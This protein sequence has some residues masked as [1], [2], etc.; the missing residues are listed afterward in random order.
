MCGFIATMA[1]THGSTF[2][3]LSVL[4]SCTF[5]LEMSADEGDIKMEMSDFDFI[6]LDQM[7]KEAFIDLTPFEAASWRVMLMSNENAPIRNGTIIGFCRMPRN[8]IPVVKADDNELILGFGFVVPVWPELQ[9]F[10]ET[11]PAKARFSKLQQTVHGMT[12]LN[13]ISM[14]EFKSSWK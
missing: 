11:Q 10:L 3:T 6:P 9:V 8:L 2:G 5:L 1:V 13:R 7:D 4:G 14:R 12:G